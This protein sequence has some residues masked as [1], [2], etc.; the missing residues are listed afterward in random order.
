MLNWIFV[1]K[2]TGLLR[3]GG[4]QDTLGGHIVGPWHWNEADDNDD[5][6]EKWL[7]LENTA[8]GFVA[9]QVGHGSDRKWA[10]AWDKD[11]MF[12][13]GRGSATE[14][15]ESGREDGSR[16]RRPKWVPIM[17]RRRMQLGLESRYVKDG[18]TQKK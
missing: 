11:G 4:R 14:T 8:D 17:L 18:D 10:V 2:D 9:V 15:E 13:S 6:N 1:D 7:T 12:T 16:R 3:Y 5:E